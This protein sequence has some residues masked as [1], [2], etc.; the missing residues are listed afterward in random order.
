M[1]LRALQQKLLYG[2]LTGLT[3]I[4][5]AVPLYFVLTPLVLHTLGP[6][7]F[8]IWSFST[9]IISLMNLTDFGLKNSLIYHVAKHADQPSEVRRYFSTTMWMYIALSSL[10]LLATTLWGADM[11]CAL[12]KVPDHYRGEAVF[13]LWMTV[14]GFVWRLLATP[15]QALLEGH[16]EL[17]SSQL[18]SLA[19][20]V[21][22][23]VGSLAALAVTPTIY[24]LGLAGLAGNV[25]VF[26]AYFWMA[27][28][29]FPQIR[30]G[31]GAI[32]GVRLRQIFGFGF[33]IQVA[34][35]CIA[36]REPLYKVLVANS[37][38]LTS[39]ASFDIAFKLCTQLMSV[40]TTPLL[41]LFGAAALL[42]ARRDDLLIVLRPLMG[43]TLGLLLPTALAVTSFAKPL[44]HVWLGSATLAT[45]ALLPVMC[46]AFAIYYS[47]EALYR[48]IEGTGLSLYSA[49][50]Q[51][52]VL[53]LQLMCFWMFPVH[54]VSVAAWSIMAGYVF[55]SLSNLWM[56][57]IRFSGG[58]IFTFLQWAA[59]SAPSVLYGV[60]LTLIPIELRPVAFGLYLP[61]HAWLLVSARIVDVR[62]LWGQLLNRPPVVR[63]TLSVAGGRAE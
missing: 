48:T 55:F 39:V 37:L 49:V 54:D 9:I 22:Y 18:I 24:G 16:Q 31:K 7:Q 47:T 27:R 51:A 43:I 5:L 11:M 26:L 53:T 46:V 2:S 32:D 56:F 19:W 17:S 36:M 38:D 29:R 61:L 12:L 44:L 57:R 3:R 60:C 10:A 20:L 1:H 30:L 41:G 25:F 15:Y 62:L 45:D 14:A 28:R 4:A 33:G 50:V 59:L 34:S 6:E 35:I 42:A 23:F 13:V 40:I 63:P 52:V 21:V 8:G 58:R